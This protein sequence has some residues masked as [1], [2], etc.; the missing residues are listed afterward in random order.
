MSS[1]YDFAGDKSGEQAELRILGKGLRQENLPKD[2]LIKLLKVGVGRHLLPA[3]GDV[4]SLK[5]IQRLLYPASAARFD[6]S[7][8]ACPQQAG[9][10]LEQAS[11]EESSR[12]A[13]SELAM[14]LVH[15]S[16]IKHRDKVGRQT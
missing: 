10:V 13:A 7:N 8:S 1:V 6:L 5:R 12:E 3:T 16:V 11:Q 4:A 2:S 9:E 14:A 15:K